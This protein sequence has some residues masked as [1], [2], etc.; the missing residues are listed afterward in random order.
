MDQSHKYNHG[1]KVIKDTGKLYKNMHRVVPLRWNY[2]CKRMLSIIQVIKMHTCIVR[3]VDTSGEK[4][5]T[6]SEK[7]VLKTGNDIC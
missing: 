1:E 3:S 2:L 6:G 7:A 4:G 5:R